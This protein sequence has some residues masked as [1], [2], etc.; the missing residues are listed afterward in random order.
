[1]RWK[2]M[3]NLALMP[4]LALI[5]VGCGDPSNDST[6]AGGSSGEVDTL[7]IEVRPRAEAEPLTATLRCGTPPEATGFIGDAEKAC[8]TV[9]ASKQVL[10]HGPPDNVMCTEIY[11]G[12]QRARITGTLEGQR[13]DLEVTREDGCA[14]ALWDELEPLLG[15]P[16]AL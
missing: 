5:A 14:I 8:R 13:V 12:P 9:R 16:P 10:I 7:R 2:L 15:A 3:R 11:G 1:M 4:I 6:P